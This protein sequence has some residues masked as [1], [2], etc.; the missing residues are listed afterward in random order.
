MTMPDFLN[1]PLVKYY[2]SAVIALYP[3]ARIFMRAGLRPVYAVLLAVPYIG[4]ILCLA[5]LARLK[6]KAPVI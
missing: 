1:D 6:W 3:M 2:I 5:A 4:F